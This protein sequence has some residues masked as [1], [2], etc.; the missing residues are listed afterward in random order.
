MRQS[1]W[2]IAVAVLAGAL[3]V[4]TCDRAPTYRHSDFFQFWAAPRLLLEGRDPYDPGDW[5]TIY[6]REARPPVATPPPPGRHIYPLWSAVPLLP[7]ALLPVETAASIWIV[8]QTAAVGLALVVLGRTFALAPAERALLFGIAAGYQ[9]L[10]L[11]VGGGNVTGFMLAV[12]AAAIA[13][14]HRR[15][16]LAGA[17]LSVLAMKPHPFV[18]S[19]PVV[20]LAARP[21]HRLRVA[22]AAAVALAGLVAI[23]LPLGPGWIASWLDAALARQ[24]EPTGSNATVWTIGRV[25]PGAPVIAPVVVAGAIAALVIWWRVVEPPAPVLVAG[26][27]A[28]SVLVALHGW[29]YDQ[30]LLLVTLGAILGQIGA[31][32]GK[33]RIA[34]LIATSMIL[35]VLPW[36]LYAIAL[37]RSGE[38]WSAITPLLT[39][40]LL[41]TVSAR[42]RHRPV[43]TRYGARA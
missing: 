17:T 11:I 31:L 7:L 40:G 15:P 26:A 27:V 32:A 5:A 19:A 14:L 42:A 3:S 28:V 25:I 13:L 16:I 1:R 37:Q 36:L 4:V 6:A 22:I 39:F 9:P 34:A 43:P 18:L 41:A 23:A 35:C 30:T 33:A 29:S 10:W 2:I 12:V 24:L 8:A 21:E 20:L 38:E